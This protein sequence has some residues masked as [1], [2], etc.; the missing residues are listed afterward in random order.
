[1]FNKG[2]IVKDR[3]LY[4]NICKYMRLWIFTLKTHVTGSY[5]YAPSII[6]LKTHRRRYLQVSA[7]TQ[8]GDNDINGH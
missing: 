3:V 5:I 4:V 1:M 7:H 8:K 6:S 2:L